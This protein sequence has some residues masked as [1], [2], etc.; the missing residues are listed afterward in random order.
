MNNNT[1]GFAVKAFI[2]N[3]NNEILIIKKS[4]KEDIGRLDYDIPGGRLEFGEK[5]EEALKRE[6]MEELNVELEKIISISN[7]W[8][9]IKPE[10]QFQ[11]IGNDFIVKVKSTENIKLSFEHTEYLWISKENYKSKNF[12]EWLVLTLDKAFLCI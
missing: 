11:L 3:Q 12:P 9:I 2:T 7:V 4:D 5:P 6:L 10:K 1:F 8:T